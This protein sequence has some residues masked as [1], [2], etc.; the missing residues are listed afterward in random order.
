KSGASAISPRAQLQN[1][2]DRR[3]SQEIAMPAQTQLYLVTPTI[4]HCISASAPLSLSLR[5]GLIAF[6]RPSRA[7]TRRACPC[8]QQIGKLLPTR[9]PES[10]IANCK[11]PICTHRRPPH[12]QMPG[13]EPAAVR[14][15]R[16]RNPKVTPC[17]CEARFLF[18][19]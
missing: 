6:E 14:D 8:V 5:Y 17:R 18:R 13:S 3:A 16:R 15:L 2:A 9:G 7:S 11:E 4:G 19:A 1:K 12:V 10:P